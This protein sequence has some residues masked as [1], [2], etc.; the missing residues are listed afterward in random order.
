[1]LIHDRDLVRDMDSRSTYNLCLDRLAEC[2]LHEHCP[3]PEPTPLP[4][5]VLDCT[6]PTHPHLYISNG[7]ERERYAALSYVWGESQPWKTTQERLDLF[8]TQIDISRIPQ[9]IRDAIKV[10]QELGLRY[11]WVDS[12][13][14]IQDSK[15]DK[16]R[17]I[18]RMR[19]IFRNAYVVVSAASATKA[20]EGFLHNRRFPR[21]WKDLPTVLPFRHPDM[22]SAGT[23]RVV[24]FEENE[25]VITT[26]AWCLEERLLSP[27]NL[28]YCSDTLRYECQAV[29][30]A[31]DARRGLPHRPKERLP[32]SI[33]LAG[34]RS[35]KRPGSA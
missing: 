6:N 25:E 18:S 26:R 27:R 35:I 4:T 5:R 14:I 16:S 15:D 11:L 29:Q 10:T 21:F 8:T 23:M 17:E 19:T 24:Q 3:R 34:P 9:T 33:F 22:K 12:F 31:I 13:C 2:A 7:K 32:N 30:M 20:S 1:M 28:T